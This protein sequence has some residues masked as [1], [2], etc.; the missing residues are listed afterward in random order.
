[1]ISKSRGNMAE[2]TRRLIL[3]DIYNRVFVETKRL[4]TE[5]LAKR[6]NVS[7]T[8][9]RE[10]LIQLERE[11]LVESNANSGYQLRQISGEELCEIYEIRERLEP[12]AAAKL[13]EADPSAETIAH[14]RS[15]CA[16]RRNAECF[17]ELL[18]ADRQF[19]QLLCDRCGAETLRNI[20]RNFLILSTPF[21]A[22]PSQDFRYDRRHVSA[23]SDEHDRI[24]DAIEAGNSKLAERLLRD[25]I[26][27]ARKQIVKNLKKQ[28]K[29]SLNS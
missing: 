17:E 29:R 2:Y 9:V 13:A 27:S 21:S 3:E 24:V 22:T 1:M 12:L 26:A 20:I 16:D 19:H 7:R 4:T 25:H 18:V 14:L 5:N 23:V 6:Y 15:L 8:P 28:N 10:A 11:G